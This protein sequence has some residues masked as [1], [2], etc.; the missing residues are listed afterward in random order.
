[1]ATRS[2]NNGAI[3]ESLAERFDVNTLQQR[4]KW[5]SKVTPDIRVGQLVLLRNSLLPPC[6]W[7]LGRVIARH[8][9][10]DGLKSSSQSKL[11]RRNTSDR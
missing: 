8:P 6:K 1:M 11:Q 2:S 5:K 9:G 10:S 4:A 7:E 3:L